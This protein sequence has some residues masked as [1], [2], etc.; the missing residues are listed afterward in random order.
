MHARQIILTNGSFKDVIEIHMKLVVTLLF[1][2]RQK[3][4]KMVANLGALTNLWVEK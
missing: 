3:V 1:G 2:N 4:Q